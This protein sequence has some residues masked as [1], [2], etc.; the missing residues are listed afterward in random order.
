MLADTQEVSMRF[1]LNQDQCEAS[2]KKNRVTGAPNHAHQKLPR[3]TSMDILPEEEEG[4][5][6]SS[7]EPTQM[8][9]PVN[10]RHL[11]ITG[12]AL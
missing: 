1:K 9:G 3:T 10:V 5:K 11:K 2:S 6:P 12:H 4:Y 7:N 8:R